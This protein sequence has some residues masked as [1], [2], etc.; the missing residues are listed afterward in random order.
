VQASDTL[1]KGNMVVVLRPKIM[2]T[3]VMDEHRICEAHLIAKV[4][5]RHLII[6][7]HKPEVDS[8]IEVIKIHPIFCENNRA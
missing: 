2:I 1:P 8:M 4:F 3:R 7:V 5:E 6:N